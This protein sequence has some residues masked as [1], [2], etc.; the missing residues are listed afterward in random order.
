M[1]HNENLG[2]DF[3]TIDELLNHASGELDGTK[4]NTQKAAARL[5]A[6]CDYSSSGNW[7]NFSKRIK[8][9][10]SS[11]EE[12]L[13]KLSICDALLKTPSAYLHYHKLLISNKTPFKA[14]DL[15]VNGEVNKDFLWNL[16]S[17]C[18]IE[19]SEKAKLTVSNKLSDSA[20]NDLKKLLFTRLFELAQ[21][22]L[23]AQVQGTPKKDF[24]NG[25]EKNNDK[26][27]KNNTFV[28]LI[29]IIISQWVDVTNEFLL[30]LDKDYTAVLDTFFGGR[31]MGLIEC[32]ECSASDLHNGGRSVYL[33]Y[34]NSKE[35]FIY[36]PKQLKL[37]EQLHQLVAD[38]NSFSGS[39]DIKVPNVISMECYGWSEYIKHLPCENEEAMQRFYKRSGCLIALFHI[40]VATDMHEENIIAAGEFPVPID[41]EML[42]QPYDTDGRDSVP[43]RKSYE[44]AIKIIE[45]SVAMI[46]LLPSYKRAPKKRIIMSGGLALHE[47]NFSPSS[48]NEDPSTQINSFK[49]S[50]FPYFGET[51]GNPKNYVN[52]I[53]LG[54]MEYSRFLIKIK[55]LNGVDFIYSRFNGLKVRRVYRPTRF[56]ELLLTRLKKKVSLN[57]VAVWSAEADF[58]SRFIDWD[59]DT[60]SKLYVYKSERKALLE[61]NIPFFSVGVDT[62]LVFSDNQCVGEFHGVPGLRR[63]YERLTK[64]DELEISRQAEI[65]QLSFGSKLN[66]LVIVDDSNVNSINESDLAEKKKSNFL[67]ES[68]HIAE[69]IKS[70]RIESDQSVSWIGLEWLGDSRI[71]QLLPLRTDL[72]SGSLG[73]AIFLAAWGKANKS[74]DYINL[75]LKAAAYASHQLRSNNGERLANNVGL[76]GSVGVGSMIYGLAVLSEITSKSNLL[77]DAL[78]GSRLITPKIILADR[79]FDVFDGVAGAILSLLSLHKR[80]DEPELLQRAVQ[81]GQH[82][83]N[84]FSIN[85]LDN[86]YG[87]GG[88]LLNGMSHGAAGIAYAL[89]WLANSSGREDFLTL[90]DKFINI[91]NGTYCKINH[92]WPDFRQGMFSDNKW[93]CQWCHGAAG[94]GLA[95]IASSRMTHQLSKAMLHDI[96]CSIESITNFQS[97]LSDTLCCGSIGNI[98][99]LHEASKALRRPNLKNEAIDILYSTLINKKNSGSYKWDYGPT[100]YNIGL[101]KG[102]SGVGYTMLRMTGQNLPNLLIWE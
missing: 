98:E 43:S 100:K 75:S 48:L 4:E 55:N 30:R 2:A 74:N 35:A 50:N 77:D 91:E 19:L 25:L 29:L 56:Y 64:L 73:I 38:L 54:F 17:Q 14:I 44:V 68:E 82:L 9:E 3:A 59:S 90:A 76:G 63:G 101:F 61:L 71:A 60:D 26:N 5:A 89:T 70:I 58:V 66:D 39:I 40:L 62:N 78:I 51:L 83:I 8:L 13:S 69:F 7:I 57:D 24:T 93:S 18:W 11:Y 97:N 94:I 20:K 45:D 65:I 95:R 102:L 6:W 37:D 49:V 53:V 1:N 34:F 12:I 52:E 31:S 36:K 80:I 87:G 96:E 32:V 92:N 41:L 46:G 16:T 23:D 72:Y 84:H 99:L 85:H 79:N 88:V 22:F 21:Y 15:L 27:N 81:C 10:S 86:F 47:K 67:Q 28:R 33:L 42:L